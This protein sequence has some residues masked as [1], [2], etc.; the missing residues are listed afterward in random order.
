MNFG[1]ILSKEMDRVNLIF[2]LTGRVTVA[3]RLKAERRK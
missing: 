3:C 1:T 2:A